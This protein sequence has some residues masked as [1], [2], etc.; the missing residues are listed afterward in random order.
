MELLKG[1][2]LQVAQWLQANTIP[3]HWKSML[4]QQGTSAHIYSSSIRSSKTSIPTCHIHSIFQGRSW[5]FVFRDQ[6]AMKFVTSPLKRWHLEAFNLKLCLCSLSRMVSKWSKCWSK[7]SENPTIS[8]KFQ[9]NKTFFQA[10]L[11]H[12]F[13]HKGLKC[14]RSITETKRH[15]IVFI[16][17]KFAYLKWH[18]V[19]LDSVT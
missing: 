14:G 4:L 8:S 2:K 18:F 7:V 15:S 5:F 17:P 6:V 12:S 11:F 3:C 19:Y 13:I 9:V 10:K 16:E 1:R